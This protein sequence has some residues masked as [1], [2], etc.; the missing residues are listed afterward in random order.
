[1]IKPR[2]QQFNAF[3]GIIQTPQEVATESTIG[4]RPRIAGRKAIEWYH[5]ENGQPTAVVDGHGCHFSTIV[6]R[7]GPT[8]DYPERRSK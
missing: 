8:S 4:V 1:M 2:N 6:D 3:D 5:A 7:F